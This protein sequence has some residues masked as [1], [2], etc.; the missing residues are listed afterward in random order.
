MKSSQ[1]KK[2]SGPDITNSFALPRSIARVLRECADKYGGKEP[3]STSAAVKFLWINLS[4][5]GAANAGQ[6]QEAKRHLTHEDWLNVVDEAASLGVKYIVICA[7]A[8][9]GAY[10]EVWKI[11]RWAQQVHGIDVG[12]HTRAPKL[13]ESEINELKR[14]N[15]NHTWLFVNGK[16]LSAFGHLKEEGIK[17]LEAQVDDEE[18]SPP[19]D[20]PEQIVFVGPKGVLYT[21]GLVLNDENFRMG[22][23]SERPL[24]QFLKDPNLPHT[25]PKGVP[26]RKSGCD[27]CPPIMAKRMSGTKHVK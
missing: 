21:C 9:L 19:C 14:L 8:S 2:G 11:C 1:R 15:R 20:M 25:I 3:S 12:V 24:E 7:G 4:D 27:A 17:V 18:Q 5:H 6:G 16:D 26:H 10:P 22:H 23:V 13:T